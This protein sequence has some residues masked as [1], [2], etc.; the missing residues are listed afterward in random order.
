MRHVALY[1]GSLL[2]LAAGPALAANA[3]TTD[4]VHMYAGPNM[5]YPEVMRLSA[6]RPVT[7][8]GCL[9][10]VAWCDV[11][12]RGNRGWVPAGALSTNDK[13]KINSSAQLNVPQV[14]FDVRTYWEQNYQTRPWYA[15]RGTW[16]SEIGSPQ[17]A[18]PETNFQT[19][20][21]E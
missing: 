16:Y 8:H 18:V 15:D 14:Q 3:L 11:E 9:A 12:W 4:A 20:R 2:A 1:A 6:G 19:A 10:N 13:S 7:L 17:K 21:S 5:N